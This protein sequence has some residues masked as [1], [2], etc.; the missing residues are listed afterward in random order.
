MF[1]VIKFWLMY[2]F[3]NLNFL[4]DYLLISRDF[5]LQLNECLDIN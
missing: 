5:L 3:Q 1:L 4:I 2:E